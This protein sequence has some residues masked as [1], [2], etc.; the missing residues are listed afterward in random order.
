MTI[1]S[2]VFRL[3][4]LFVC[5]SSVDFCDYDEVLIQKSMDIQDCFKLLVF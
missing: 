1:F 5:V 2:V 4:F 3:L